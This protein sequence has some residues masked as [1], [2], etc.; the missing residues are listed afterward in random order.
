ME[1]KQSGAD[2]P[3]MQWRFGG[4][5]AYR[6]L[7]EAYEAKWGSVPPSVELQISNIARLYEQVNK[8][9]EDSERHS[10]VETVH[11]GRQQFTKVRKSLGE[12]PRMM[13]ELQRLMDA[14][15]L[16]PHNPR[17]GERVEDEDED[18]PADEDVEAFDKL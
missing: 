13:R 18:A 5:D 11:N 10:A 3:A 8:L 7:G 12:I 17:G 14:L 16:A 4:Q 9:F 6:K 15:K 2:P 1:Q